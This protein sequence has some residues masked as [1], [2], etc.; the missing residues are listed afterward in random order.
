MCAPPSIDVLRRRFERLPREQRDAIIA[1][2]QAIGVRRL[3]DAT[4]RQLVA[5]RAIVDA[6]ARP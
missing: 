2:C 5:V 3:P 1:A 4:P 6:V